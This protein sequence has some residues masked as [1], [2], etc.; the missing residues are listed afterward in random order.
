VTY[1]LALST[2][3]FHRFGAGPEGKEAPTIFEMVD[4]C[5]E[6]GVEGIEILGYHLRELS[7]SD[8]LALRG[9][10]LRRGVE[11]VS[12]SANHNFVEPDAIARRAQIDIVA[13]WVDAAAILGAPV[14]RAFGGRWTT[15][16]WEQFMAADGI[17]PPLP[18]HSEDDGFAWSIEAFKIATYYAG[19]KGVTL[20][21]ENHWGLTGRAAGVL[22]IVDA[23]D[24][25]WLRV[26]LD[27]GNFPS[28]PDM[29]AEMAMIAP[30]AAMV[31]AKTYVGGGLYYAV[32]LD[33]TWI[34]R[35]LRE[36]GYNG[37]VSIEH[38]GKALP[39]DGIARAVADLRAAFA[40]I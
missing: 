22:R 11:V 8:L 4:R 13:R 38:E 9:H 17:E 39:A 30:K 15:L 18:G 16:P 6:H 29:Y 12:V 20:A 2:Y 26:A 28:V 40:A 31:H 5:A 32:D 35:M 14:V 1:R 23:V 19:R 10:A 25:E 33:Y 24:S 21:V 27:T 36:V 34:G 3:S 7:A 37:Y